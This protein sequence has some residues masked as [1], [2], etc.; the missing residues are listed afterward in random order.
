MLSTQEILVA[1][2]RNT[3]RLGLVYLIIA[4]GTELSIRIG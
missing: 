4:K 3:S 1:T 2:A